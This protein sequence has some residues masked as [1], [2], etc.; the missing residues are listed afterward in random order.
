MI[1]HQKLAQL[2]PHEKEY[3]CNSTD[4]VTN[5]PLGTDILEKVK[6]N[7]GKTGNLQTQ[8]RLRIGAPVVVTS[9]HSKQKYREDGIVNGAR[10]Y[11]QAIQVNK[12]NPDKVDVI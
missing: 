5:L 10:G 12:N 7:P 6:D 4:R 11:I 3:E 1:N 9:N 2:L 8:L